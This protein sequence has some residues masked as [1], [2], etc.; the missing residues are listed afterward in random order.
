MLKVDIPLEYNNHIKSPP[1]Y[2]EIGNHYE[3]RAV[4]DSEKGKVNISINDKYVG[5]LSCIRSWWKFNTINVKIH[6]KEYVFNRDNYL[7]HLSDLGITKITTQ[8]YLLEISKV[9]PVTLERFT[10]RLWYHLG[11]K[12]KKQLTTDYHA[13]LERND[14]QEAINLVKLGVPLNKYYTFKCGLKT[15]IFLEEPTSAEL[16]KIHD[17]SDPVSGDSHF[18]TITCISHSPLT[19]LLSSEKNDIQADKR[20]QLIQLLKDWGTSAIK[21]QKEYKVYVYVSGGYKSTR[22]HSCKITK[23]VMS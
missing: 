19:A 12:L 6:N 22:A 11:S 5:Q 7:Q 9:D 13:A 17:D 20:T 21:E 15:T 14:F 8:D 2:S 3:I 4:F 16:C 18:D 1:E 10:D 23:H